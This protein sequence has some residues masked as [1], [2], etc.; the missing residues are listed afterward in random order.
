MAIG[1][2]FDHQHQGDLRPDAA[3]DLLHVMPDLVQIHFYVGRPV[4]HG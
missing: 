2:H 3:A 1:V 4:V